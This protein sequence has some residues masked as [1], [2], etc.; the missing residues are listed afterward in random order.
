MNFHTDAGGQVSEQCKQ[1][2]SQWGH[3]KHILIVLEWR[4]CGFFFFNNKVFGWWTGQ[5]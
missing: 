1:D 5:E 4:D 2:C 3:L